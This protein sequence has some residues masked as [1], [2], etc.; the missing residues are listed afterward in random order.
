MRM[1]Y[2]NEEYWDVFVPE[3]NLRLQWRRFRYTFAEYTYFLLKISLK[4]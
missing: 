3:R 1:N 4:C 2:Y